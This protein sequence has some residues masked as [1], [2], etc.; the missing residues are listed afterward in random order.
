MSQGPNKGI[1]IRFKGQWPAS[2]QPEMASRTRWMTA[3][4]TTH[5]FSS[6]NDRSEMTC[7]F[8]DYD[9]SLLALGALL[10][11]GISINERL[12]SQTL[13]KIGALNE[14]MEK[15]KPKAKVYDISRGGDGRS[16]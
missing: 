16:A 15:R 1:E 13:E 11:M 7:E 9:H 5:G 3:P 8:R 10:G 4:N 12:L 2:V 14:S 6:A